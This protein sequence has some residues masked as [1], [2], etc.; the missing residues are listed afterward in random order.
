VDE[1]IE[2]DINIYGS[3]ALWPSGRLLN[4]KFGSKAGFRLISF[5]LMPVRYN[6]TI[7]N[8]I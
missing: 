2:T 8:W 3:D 4:V 7:G 5:R 1:I 6:P